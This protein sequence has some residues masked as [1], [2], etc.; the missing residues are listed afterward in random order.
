MKKESSYGNTPLHIACQ[1]GDWV[2]VK[3]LFIACQEASYEI[4]YTGETP[5]HL[6]VRSKSFDCLKI[7]KKYKV[8][9]LNIKNKDGENPLFLAARQ[10]N[11]WIFRFFTGKID[12]F[13]AWGDRNYKGETIEHV[14]C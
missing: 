6:A 5:F 11:K 9:S 13:K 4:N 8:Q 2:A 7:M 3:L 14:V 12:F 10:G 1:K